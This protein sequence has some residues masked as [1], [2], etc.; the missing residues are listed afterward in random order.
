LIPPNIELDIEKLCH[1]MSLAQLQKHFQFY[2]E[3]YRER[4]NSRQ[5]IPGKIEKICYLVTRFPATFAAASYVFNEARRCLGDFHSLLDLGAGPGT[6]LIAATEAGFSLQKATLIEENKEFLEQGSSW[7]PNFA[8][9]EYKDLL[10]I[11]QLPEHEVSV[12]CYS[13]GEIP[14]KKQRNL[15]KMAWEASQKALILIE[16]GTP[17]AFKNILEARKDLI[18]MGGN[19]LAPCPHNLQCPLILKNDWCHFSV[20]LQRTSLHRK[21]KGGNLGYE[22]EKFCYMILAKNPPIKTYP[23]II[24]SPKKHAGYVELELCTKEGIIEKK[25]SSRDKDKFKIAKDLNWGELCYLED[26]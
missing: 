24:K 10:K 22:D 7:C 1:G 12:F 26:S 20:R 15:L 11:E 19:V 23:R 5:S 9:R 25:I 17:S 21:I 2:S 8:K 16:P 3:R 6:A 14:R 13:L 18:E 4:K